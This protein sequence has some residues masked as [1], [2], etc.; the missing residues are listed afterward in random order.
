MLLIWDFV[1]VRDDGSEVSLHPNYSDTKIQC[2][3]IGADVADHE[4]PA[5][6]LGGTSG[7]GTFRYFKNNLFHESIQLYPNDL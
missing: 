2:Y 1:L 4:L 5:S 7:R 3:S 6:G